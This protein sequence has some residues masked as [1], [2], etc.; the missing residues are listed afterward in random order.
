M[1]KTVVTTVIVA[2][3]FLS[4]FS[5]SAQYKTDN[6]PE[7]APKAE[8]Q[9]ILDEAADAETPVIITLEQA[10]EIALSEMCR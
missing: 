7:D 10:L 9:A 6:M 4:S 1:K 2:G 8:V 5:A 3:A